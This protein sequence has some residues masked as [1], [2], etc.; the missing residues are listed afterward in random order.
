MCSSAVRI[1]KNNKI[2]FQFY[3]SSTQATLVCK[4]SWNGMTLVNLTHFACRS[5]N[6]WKVFPEPLTPDKSCLQIARTLFVFFLAYLPPIR[7]RQVAAELVGLLQ[8]AWPEKYKLSVNSLKSILTLRWC[9]RNS[10]TFL[11][12][13][14]LR[15]SISF[16][17][18]DECRFRESMTIKL[19]SRLR[20]LK[21]ILWIW[22]F[23]EDTTTYNDAAM[24]AKRQLPSNGS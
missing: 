24:D 9:T 22:W 13:D 17:I 5:A 23:N 3:T 12:C 2:Q 8:H 18:F 16:C 14:T 4:M 1:R 11:I 7:F 19:S 6:Q 10:T 15:F 20:F 21:S